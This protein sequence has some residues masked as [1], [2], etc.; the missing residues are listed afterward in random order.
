MII[1]NFYHGTNQYHLVQLYDAGTGLIG[2]NWNEREQRSAVLGISCYLGYRANI[3]Y[4]AKRNEEVRTLL[5]PPELY[6]S[7]LPRLIIYF[8][9]YPPKRMCDPPTV[10]G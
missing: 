8:I 5:N 9:I 4:V 2:G 7:N 10:G 6:I 3:L 1:S